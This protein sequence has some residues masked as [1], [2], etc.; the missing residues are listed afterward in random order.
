MGFVRASCLGPGC[1]RVRFQGSN[2]YFSLQPSLRHIA[3]STK[4][5]DSDCLRQG[6]PPFFE[7]SKALSYQ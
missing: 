3:A 5:V 2:G 7:P 6:F 4:R 1:K